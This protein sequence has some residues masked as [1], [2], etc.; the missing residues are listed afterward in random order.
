MTTP[1]LQPDDELE[2]LIA[3]YAS[4][5]IEALDQVPAEVGH[6]AARAAAQIILDHQRGETPEGELET[7]E[8]EI[9]EVIAATLGDL[10]EDT[11]F[12][13]YEIQPPES[14]IQAA[15]V[16]AAQVFIAFERG[17]RIH[18]CETEE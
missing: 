16:A 8:G 3:R 14:V 2:A 4:N 12:R 13:L 10:A 18:D 15:A 1:H 6:A 5:P 7:L 17:Y 11:D 9:T